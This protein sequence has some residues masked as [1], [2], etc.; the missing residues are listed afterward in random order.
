MSFDNF[1]LADA[2]LEI[3]EETLKPV[4][5]FVIINTEILPYC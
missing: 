3:S 2:L 4:S 1:I 5:Q